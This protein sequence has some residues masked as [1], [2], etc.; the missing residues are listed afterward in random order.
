[1][2]KKESKGGRRENNWLYR[3][4]VV[5]LMLAKTLLELIL[6]LAVRK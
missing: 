6:L 5:L 2:G 4:T 1:M 3:Q